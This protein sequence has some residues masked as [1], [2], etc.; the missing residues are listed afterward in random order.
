LRGHSNHG[1]WTFCV[2]YRSACGAVAATVRLPA[3]SFPLRAR[4]EISEPGRV[5][6]DAKHQ[7]CATE[8]LVNVTSP[9]AAAVSSLPSGWG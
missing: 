1:F 9:P 7:P 2:V 5:L 4:A 8:P 3:S 6:W